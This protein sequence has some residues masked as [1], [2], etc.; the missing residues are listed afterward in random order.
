MH[1]VKRIHLPDAFYFVTVVTYRRQPILTRNYELFRVS[2]KAQKLLAWVLLPDHFHALLIPEHGSISQVMHR[3]KITFAR[4]YRD[5]FGGGRVWQN[6]YWDHIIRDD[7]DFKRH[8][9][10]IHYNPVKHRQA[11][12]P[13][14]YEYSS[15]HRYLAR[16][17][18]DEQWAHFQADTNSEFGE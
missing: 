8:L 5:E 10:Y 14:N 11:D 9:D 17:Y 12:I 3:F 13:R 4:S 16:G 1:N 2:W 18:Y 15:F 6:R 7:Q